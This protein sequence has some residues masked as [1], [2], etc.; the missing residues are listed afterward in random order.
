MARALR[1]LCRAKWG[2]ETSI[3]LKTLGVA[4][5]VALAATGA[6]AATLYATGANIVVD[7]P[8]GT[9]N[10]RDDITNAFG[11]ADGAFFELGRFATVDFT[12]GQ[13]F[14]G[15][16]N[17]VEVTFGDVASF[18]ESVD[19]FGLQDGGDPVFLATIGNLDA[20]D[21]DGATFA[22]NGIYDTLR[23]VDTSLAPNG[24][25]RGGFDVDSI[26]VAAIPLPAAG[27]LLLGALGALG[28]ARRRAA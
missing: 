26:A 15:P 6:S 17:I 20:E 18:P 25:L 8:R 14:R 7:G 5:L 4:A 3:V 1:A 2:K 23:L 10:D 9:E 16:G 21:E 24:L 13:D 19:V 12:F 27:L 28:L 11:E 22:F